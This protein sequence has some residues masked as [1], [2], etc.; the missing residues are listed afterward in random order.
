MRLSEGTISL[1]PSDLTAYL[2]CEHLTQLELAVARG[3]LARPHRD[4]P[5]S[6]LIRLKGVE[7]EAAYL[8]QLRD[9]GRD[10]VEIRVE[11]DDGEWDWERAAHETQDAMRAGREVIYQAAFVDGHWHGLA[12]FVVRQP[13]GGYEAVDTKLARHPKP[14]FV[15]QLCFYSEQIGRLQG[16]LPERLHV[17]LGTGETASFR[18]ADFD[19]YYRRVR[20]RFLDAVHRPRE[21]E[22][23]PCDHCALCDFKELCDAWWDERD[24]LVRVAGIRRDQIARLAG[25]GI[26]TLEQLGSAPPETEVER[27]A[28]VTFAKLRE[29]A[30]LQLRHRLGGE[31]TWHTLAPEAERGLA[32]LPKPSPGDLFVD[33]EGDPFWEPGR[34]LEY[35]LGVTE[36]DGGEPRFRAF[37]AH[38]RDEERRAFEQF[39]DFVHERLRADPGLRVYHYAPYEPSALKRLAAAF[40]TREE[41]VDD[42]L[43]GE[44]LVD[45]YAVVRQGLRISHPR[46][47]LKNVEQFF[48]RRAAELRAGDDSILLY[49]RW[50]EERDP[51]ILQAIRDYN[52]EDCLSTYLLREW[53][54]ERK[55]EA[56]AEWGTEI[57]WREPP[58]QREPDEEAVEEREERERL[59]DELLERGETLAARLLDYHRREAKPVWWAFFD[60]LEQTSDELVEDAEAIG[61]LELVGEVAERTYDFRFPLQ[62][63][64]LDPGDGVID[65]VTGQGTGTIVELDDVAG[66]LRLHRG[67]KVDERP[68]PR[69]LIPGG[70]YDTSCQ[71]AAL[72]RFGRALGTGRY[73]ALESVL[74]REPP[75]GG[76][77]VQVSTL[78]EAKELVER[79][80]GRH[81]FVQGPPGSGKTYSGARLIVHLLGRGKRVG[82]SA[83]S[84]KAIHNLLREIERA[85]VEEGVEFR[86]LKRGDGGESRYEGRFVTTAK[87]G[88][89]DPEVGL[90]AGTAW[91]HARPELDQTLD[92]LFVDEAGQV[93]L[94][95][96][97]A[98]GTA[99][100]TL[101]LL[102]D[103]LQLA[104]V[105]QAIHPDG[106]GVSVLE[107]L[108]GEDQTI[109]EDRGLFL[110]R[111]YR[112][113]P[114][115]C[116]FVSDAFYESR[117]DSAEGCERQTTAAGVGLRFLPV[118]H[119]ANRR[120]SLEEAVAIRDEIRRLLGAPWTNA[121][122]VT[123]PLRLGDVLVVAPY[124]EQVGLLAETLPEGARVGTVDKFQGQEGAVVFF[125]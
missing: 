1:S 59:C 45:L 102:G 99:A 85:A 22:P 36:L 34:G 46:Y 7:H 28:A 70:P 77:R 107:H 10:V 119:V 58:E 20:E 19:A 16:R 48:L 32:L 92:Y 8:R 53:L 84:H 55:A 78:E 35:L 41:E 96:A 66:T 80:E 110:G 29:Q 72:L 33:I 112:M 86:G 6:D 40:G 54:L 39:V 13:D 90:V 108:L 30:A 109:P 121:A 37:W 91:L 43:R 2:A 67:P 81:L 111:T 87:D 105:T 47:S 9:D 14:Y 31:H 120:S 73:A 68:L 113:H 4:D 122:G 104:Q 21:T 11:D 15:L 115:V 114:E 117:L 60:R 94:A 57:A 75:L 83:T 18:L 106:S 27:M 61:G 51:A 56:E 118:E 64:K 97:L 23:Y 79:V 50:R 89:T 17:V 82:V 24:H 62:Q 98:K 44:V 116:R 123:A 101:V 38:D 5:Q 49:E 76:A 71:R 100:R 65:P 124:N 69:A 26:E 93:S 103:P 63:H 88:F 52:E 95:D 3:D 125:S 12:D 25:A 42:L 74:R